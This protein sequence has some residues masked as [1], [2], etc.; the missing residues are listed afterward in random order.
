MSKFTLKNA[1]QKHIDSIELTDVQF[2]K[3]VDI[4]G[5]PHGIK[6]EA[7]RSDRYPRTY[8][9][10]LGIAATL[11]LVIAVGL[12]YSNQ[13]I[14]IDEEIAFEVS[15]NHLK[16]KPLEIHSHQLN[17]LSRYFTL[18]D[19]KLVDTK[20]LNDP[21][22]ELLGGRYCSVQGNTAAQLRLKNKQTGVIETLYQAPY[23]AR[24]F[25][26]APIL[27]NNQSPIN[28]YAKGMSV[29]IWVEK[30]VLFALTNND[31]QN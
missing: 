12:F 1:V 8:A 18:L 5:D 22:W 25:N 2:S 14:T 15:N 16:L 29:K 7:T 21:N 11:V 23:Y 20:I 6:S 27:E 4:Q 26:N 19:F 31:L 28:V 30:G 9:K 3:L 24:Q 17:D 10:I 13:Q